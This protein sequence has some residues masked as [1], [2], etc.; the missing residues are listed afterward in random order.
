MIEFLYLA[1]VAGVLSPFLVWG[2]WEAINKIKG[3]SES[4]KKDEVIYEIPMTLTDLQNRLY[5]LNQIGELGERGYDFCS[6]IISDKKSYSTIMNIVEKRVQFSKKE[7]GFSKT[8]S[9]KAHE[10]ILKKDLAF[11]DDKDYKISS[12]LLNILTQQSEVLFGILLINFNAIVSGNRLYW[13]GSD[14]RSFCKECTFALT[15]IDFS[16]HPKEFNKIAEFNEKIHKLKEE[17]NKYIA[18]GGKD[19]EIISLL[20]SKIQEGIKAGYEIVALLEESSGENSLEFQEKQNE[21]VLE[22]FNKT[23]LTNFDY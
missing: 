15:N 9:A 1:P 13:C 21:K 14:K 8:L 4:K 6:K 16:K 11:M 22:L 2:G 10:A 18:T 17:K 19:K 5:E 12:K 20:D 7:I 23:H 3:I